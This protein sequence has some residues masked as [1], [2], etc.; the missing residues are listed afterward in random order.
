VLCESEMFQVI[1][2]PQVLAFDLEVGLV[3]FTVLL[4]LERTSQE[5]LDLS[6]RGSFDAQQKL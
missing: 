5:L 6:R 3:P 4:V 1:R 2:I